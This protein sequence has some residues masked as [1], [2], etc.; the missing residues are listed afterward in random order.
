[1]RKKVRA[2]RLVKVPGADPR[3]CSG[4]RIIGFLLPALNGARRALNESSFAWSASDA[5]LVTSSPSP[6]HLRTVNG[7]VEQPWDVSTEGGRL[8]LATLQHYETAGKPISSGLLVLCDLDAQRAYW[9]S[10]LSHAEAASPAWKTVLASDAATIRGGANADRATEKALSVWAQTTTSLQ[11]L[12]SD[13][14]AD[15]YSF[16]I[17]TSSLVRSQPSTLKLHR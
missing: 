9:T 12:E 1:M 15:A 17:L 5:P 14:A 6:D 11:Q 4:H 16:E 3:R 10:V 8:A 2:P 13:G 7:A